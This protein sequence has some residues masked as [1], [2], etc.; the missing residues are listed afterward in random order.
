MSTIE[1]ETP[2]LSESGT[3]RRTDTAQTDRG[4]QRDWVG[5]SLPKFAVPIL[6]VATF[7]LFSVLE[8]SLFF[9]W[10]NVRLTLGAQATTLLLAVAVTVPL[11]AGDFDLSVAAVMIFSATLVGL[12][13]EHGVPAPLA[14]FI[15][16]IGVGVGV[17]LVNSLFVIAV[18]LDGLIVTL[19][20]F[21]LV[22]GVTVGIG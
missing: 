16:I 15:A 12:L 1:N 4:P 3:K 17:G 14:C 20:V 18:G 7:A 13:Y 6:L 8:P 22:T 19:G 11:R 21:T 9:T 5:E 2:N 10:T